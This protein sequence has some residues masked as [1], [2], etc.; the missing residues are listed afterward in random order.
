MEQMNVAYCAVAIFIAGLSFAGF[1]SGKFVTGHIDVTALVFSRTTFEAL[2]VLLLVCLAMA[3]HTVHAQRAYMWPLISGAWST[4]ASNH[5]LMALIGGLILAAPAAMVKYLLMPTLTWVQAFFQSSIVIESHDPSF[6]KVRDYVMTLPRDGVGAD[7]NLRAQTRRQ[8]HSWKDWQAEASG[9]A[10]KKVPKMMYISATHSAVSV[11]HNGERLWIT[12]RK[13]G[14]PEVV[15]RDRQLKQAYKIVITAMGRGSIAT[16]KDFITSAL[17]HD[18]KIEDKDTTNI[19]VQ[20]QHWWLGSWTKAME[21]PKRSKDS[22]VLDRDLADELVRDARLFLSRARWYLERGIPYRRGYLLHGPPGTGKTSFCQVLAGELDADLCLLTLTDADLTDTRLAES[23]RDAPAGAII[24]LEDVD[25][26]FV[27]RT[28]GGGDGGSGGK[29]GRGGV[30]F[31]GLLN[32][33]DGVASQEGRIFIMTTNHPEKLDPALKRPGRCD[34]SRQLNYA[35]RLQMRRLFARFY[36]HRFRDDGGRADA[37]DTGAEGFSLKKHLAR[38]AE[39]EEKLRLD[40]ATGAARPA[41]AAAAAMGDDG[42]AVPAA[43][44]D[45][46]DRFAC[47]LPEFELSMAKL[48]GYLMKHD[49]P[50]EALRSG[51]IQSLLSANKKPHLVRTVRIYDHLKR[52]GLGRLAP[53]FERHNVAFKSQL[54]DVGAKEC[55]A[56]CWAL[57]HDARTFKQLERLLSND[58]GSAAEYQ[59]ANISTIRDAF[60][61]AFPA[62]RMVE[63]SPDA[64]LARVAVPA[65]ESSADESKGAP[66]EAEADADAGALAVPSAPRLRRQVTAEHKAAERAAAGA[67]TQLELVAS[68]R[69][70]DRDARK[71]PAAAPGA[72]KTLEVRLREMAQR[73]VD[74][75]TDG[76]KITISLWQL[77]WLMLQN[78]NPEDCIAMAGAMVAPRTPDTFEARPLTSEAWLK[79]AGM[80]KYAKLFSKKHPLARDAAAAVDKAD[81]LEKC[82]VDDRADREFLFKLLKNEDKDRALTVGAS[83]PDKSSVARMFWAAFATSV[84]AQAGEKRAL[85]EA[86]S[87]F[88]RS[89][90]GALGRSR[91]SAI[92]LRAHFARHA[93]DWRAALADTQRPDG[94]L[95][96]A[97]APPPP[98]APPPRKPPRCWVFR[99]LEQKGA[100]GM[101]TRLGRRLIDAGIETRE[102][103]LSE[104]TLTAEELKEMGIDKVGDARRLLRLVDRLRA[105]G[106][107][108][109][110]EA[111]KEDDDDDDDDEKEETKETEE[112]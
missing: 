16:I 31:S 20:S 46:A 89:V 30:S 44:R 72:L 2:R 97:V 22:V 69:S 17:K 10:V 60:L 48:S 3:A 104:P 13:K 15:G 74:T 101:A 77:R 11:V 56:W 41:A 45:M 39:A 91:V 102:D 23:L 50:A 61:A 47:A 64:L 28:G 53:W 109:V 57:G 59:L 43:L 54:R 99:A 75:V 106:A 12:L 36:L 25:A 84:E 14:K 58:K 40:R 63:F 26:V 110:V 21:K 80:L 78:D 86:A 105:G 27:D 55:K 7:T 37:G 29:G 8:K 70:S 49:D 33:I 18:L 100:D 42:A 24:L 32:A 108:S 90:C 83:L 85:L 6:E 107:D 5:L 35:S 87:V 4:I 76:G 19:F 51:S 111:A 66:V 9:T 82:G 79:R 34:V 38:K 68:P 73:L 96:H 65:S 94:A 81:T 92:E 93:G 71:R 98:D 88:S 103:L 112:E 52:L 62:H 95:L 67:A 1:S